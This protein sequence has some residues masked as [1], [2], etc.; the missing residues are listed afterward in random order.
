M[1][2]AERFISEPSSDIPGPGYYPATS[3]F[4]RHTISPK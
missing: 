1:G 3:D 2:K 4:D